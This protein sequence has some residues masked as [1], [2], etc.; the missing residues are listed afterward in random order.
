MT[1][2]RYYQLVSGLPHLPYFRR[3]GRL[4]MS[5]RRLEQRLGL[6]EDDDRK[7]LASAASLI[8]WRRQPVNRTTAQVV[9][10][11]GRVMAGIR[12]EA[13]RSVVRFRMDMRTVVVA[14]RRRRKGLGVPEG[15]WGVGPYVRM[16]ETRWGETDF[17]LASVFPWIA[18]AQSHLDQGH[19]MELEGLMMD[20]SWHLMSAIADRA[21][22]G[23]EEVFSFVLKWD[24]LQR[25][26][27]YDAEKAHERFD[28]LIAEVTRDHQRLFD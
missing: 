4:P 3:A 27:S 2:R 24:I 26:L 5:R 15:P 13:L 21:P 20:R 11:Y 12:N 25:W 17:G 19:A 7:D 22:F 16:I 10:L 6:L 23:F 18:E 9:T 14:L 1:T 8:A 28:Q